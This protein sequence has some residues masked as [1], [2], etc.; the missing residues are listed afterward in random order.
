MNVQ[1]PSQS[2]FTLSF[3]NVLALGETIAG[4]SFYS[5]YIGPFFPEFF[6]RQF[7]PGYLPSNNLNPG[8]YF[9]KFP[10]KQLTSTAFSSVGLSNFSVNDVTFSGF[11]A[12]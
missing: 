9:K 12:F 11:C 5:G 7:K 6:L 4:E 1:Q 3:A 8:K 2:M 10:Q